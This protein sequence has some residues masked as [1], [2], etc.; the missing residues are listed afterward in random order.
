[1]A[2]T[3]TLGHFLTDVADAIR[4][5]TGSSE[6]IV[7][8]DFDTEIE[9]IPSGGGADLDEYF[10]TEI[11]Q[12]KTGRDTIEY[13]KKLPDLVIADNVTQVS[14]LFDNVKF[15]G[16]TNYSKVPRVVCNNNVTNM[17][18]MYNS[19]NQNTSVTEIDL[20]GLNTSNVTNMSYMF[21]NRQ[22]ITT[23]DFSNFDF[24]KVTNVYSMFYACRNLTSLDLSNLTNAPLTTANSMSY[25][26][27]LCD[28]MT[29]LDLSNFTPTSRVYTSNMFQ[30]CNKLEEIYLDKWD[31]E[32]YQP[33]SFY[34]MFSDCGSSNA[35]PTKVYVKDATAQNWILTANNGHPTTWTTDNVIIAGSS[36]DLRNA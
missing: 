21:Y 28:K 16:T 29:K 5:K 34:N 25:M 36:A 4:E 9:N 17:S 7:A 12:N 14:Y 10:V 2:R 1:M 24:S 19:Q 27:Y 6:E 18:Y 11:T 31:M 15:N 33:Y 35:T 30:Y 13:I 3:D 22:G 32:N 23:L 20:S 26:F 8:S